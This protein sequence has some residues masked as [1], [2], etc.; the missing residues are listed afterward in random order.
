MA[1]QWP[2]PEGFDGDID[3]FDL[4]DRFKTH[5][6]SVCHYTADNPTATAPAS[7]VMDMMFQ[8]NKVVTL[9]AKNL[10]DVSN[11]RFPEPEQAPVANQPVL[12][13]RLAATSDLLDVKQEVHTEGVAGDVEETAE[14]A[15]EWSTKDL[16]DREWTQQSSEDDGDWEDGS[17]EDDSEDD[18]YEYGSFADDDEED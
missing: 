5:Y 13:D 18:Y 10:S 12:Q 17:S 2:K 7:Y 3:P 1:S 8:A 4:V 15:Q 11:A 6:L 9:L 16:I 14:L